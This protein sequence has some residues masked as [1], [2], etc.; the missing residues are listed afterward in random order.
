L[1]CF[2]R[3]QYSNFRRGKMRKTITSV[4]IL[5]FFAFLSVSG[6]AWAATYSS[7]TGILHI[8][9]VNLPGFGSYDLDLHVTGDPAA[10]IQQSSAFAVQAV[11]PSTTVTEMPTPATL[12]GELLTLHIPLLAVINSEGM[13]QY[14]TADMQTILNAD[15]IQ[16]TVVQISPFQLAAVGP[17]GP[18][19]DT[20]PQGPQGA[21]GDTGATGLQGPQG[22]KGNTGATGSQGPA[23]ADGHSPVVSMSGDQ[24]TIDGVITGPHLTGPQGPAGVANG[25]SRVVMGKVDWDGTVLSGTGFTVS[26][27]SRVP[28][29]YPITFDTPFNSV[30][31]CVVTPQCDPDLF[32]THP[33]STVCFDHMTDAHLGG[34]GADGMEVTTEVLQ[35]DDQGQVTSRAAVSLPF[36]FICAE[37]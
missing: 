25:M 5:V 26:Y 34:H 28:G 3:Y 11:T 21:K 27:D 14:Y 19:G 7:T 33:E 29:G 4:A 18:K 10:P 1:K 24:I 22:P 35:T 31:S 13:I 8:P 9:A 23:G 32:Y 2:E 12:E 36:S 16:V 17:Q 6:K 30:P 20:G 37:P 15:P